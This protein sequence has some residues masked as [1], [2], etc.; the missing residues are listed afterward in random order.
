[1][2]VAK[3]FTKGFWEVLP[4]FRLV[5]GLCPTLAVTTS[6]FNG[7]G[8]G[9]AATFVLVC[10]NILVSMLRNFIPK[11][12][13]HRSLYRH[14]RQ[15]R[16]HRGTYDEGLRLFTVQGVGHLHPPHRGQLH[17][18]GPSRGIRQQKQSGSV[19]GR[20]SGRWA[21]ATRISLFVLGSIRE[22][23][24]HRRLVQ[25]VKPLRHEL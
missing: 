9:V 23:S 18:P 11:K 12:G 2:S 13:A 24:G 16:G 25:S 8:M 1:M 5:L 20:R 10:S 7:I 4:P 21:W 17:H 22:I 14:H 6:A 3:E 15:L 19:H